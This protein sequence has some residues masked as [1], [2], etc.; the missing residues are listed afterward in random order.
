MTQGAGSCA[1]PPGSKRSSD[2]VDGHFVYCGPGGRAFCPRSHG[3]WPFFLSGS[4]VTNP[5]G[6]GRPEAE[7]G[8]GE[9][10][11]P[12]AL[13][14]VWVWDAWHHPYAPILVLGGQAASAVAGSLCCLDG[15]EGED[16][17]L[18]RVGAVPGQGRRAWGGA[19][20][21]QGRSCG[22]RSS[23]Q[24]GVA[25]GALLPNGPF[26][27]PWHARPM[28][29]LRG[30]VCGDSE[31]AHRLP[32]RENRRALQHSHLSPGD[33]PCCTGPWQPLEGHSNPQGAV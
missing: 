28:V 13:A 32:P 23:L 7:S 12:A 4:A 25:V 29:K 18:I 24:A 1:G 8:H 26:L 2:L 16:A 30:T 27:H 31:G 20:L 17:E 22:A 19:W 6:A 5:G 33:A 14:T 21:C 11:A 15:V 9:S 3:T 10:W